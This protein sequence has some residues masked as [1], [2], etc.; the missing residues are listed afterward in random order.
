MSKRTLCDLVSKQLSYG[1]RY[2]Q[3]SVDYFRN[4]E[5]K[6]RLITTAKMLGINTNQNIGKIMNEIMN[7]IM[8]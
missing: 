1:G 4:K 6:E 3:K 8:K 2:S 7:I 5:A